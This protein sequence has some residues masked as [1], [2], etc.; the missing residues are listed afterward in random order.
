MAKFGKLEADGF[1]GICEGPIPPDNC[2]QFYCSE[3]CR[4]T[5]WRYFHPGEPEPDWSKL[6]EMIH[7]GCE[8]PPEWKRHYD[9]V[10]YAKM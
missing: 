10:A 5:A 4:Q 3:P 2:N 7:S 1:C 6:R 9:L 8:P